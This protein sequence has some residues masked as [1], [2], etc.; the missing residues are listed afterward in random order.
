MGW[1]FAT[2]ALVIFVWLLVIS[3]GFRGIVLLAAIGIAVAIFSYTSA[4]NKRQAKS[5]TLIQPSQL[6][7][8]NIT[9]GKTY[10][11]RKVEGTVQNNSPYELS[12]F[13]LRVIVQD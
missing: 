12:S 7:F 1:I 5:L 4:E 6:T 10:G 13:E 3:P 8:S 11:S 2:V 9:L